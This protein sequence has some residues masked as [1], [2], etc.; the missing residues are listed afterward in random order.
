MAWL[1]PYLSPNFCISL[2]HQNI[3]FLQDAFHQGNPHKCLGFS[4][5]IPR[6]MASDNSHHTRDE[7]QDAANEVAQVFS[8]VTAPSGTTTGKVNYTVVSGE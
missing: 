1:Q 7:V 3:A 2:T 5:C 8:L 4:R 6:H